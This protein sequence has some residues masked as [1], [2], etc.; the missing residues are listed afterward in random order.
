MDLFNIC[1]S[2]SLNDILIFNSFKFTSKCKIKRRSLL[3]RT[4]GPDPP[5]MTMNDALH[6]HQANAGTRKLSSSMQALKS[7]EEFVG[8]GHVETG[9]VVTHEIGCPALKGFREMFLVFNLYNSL[10]FL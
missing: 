3:H 10:Q 7:A 6:G 4:F 9:A 8:V 1:Q 2:E 5:A